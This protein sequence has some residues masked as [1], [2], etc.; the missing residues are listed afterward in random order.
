M[1]SRADPRLE[2]DAL[3]RSG[4][5]R[6]GKSYI[7]ADAECL[8][9]RGIGAVGIQGFAGRGA[10][11]SRSGRRAHAMLGSLHTARTERC[12]C[13]SMACSRL[14]APLMNISASVPTQVYWSTPPRL[15]VFYGVAADLW[16]GTMQFTSCSSVC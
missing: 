14:H 15:A 6:L 13:V 7:E 1:E 10:G 2:D 12:S 3:T 9:L 8:D 5:V 16:C 11:L 4:F